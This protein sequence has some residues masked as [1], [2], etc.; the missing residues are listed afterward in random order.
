MGKPRKVFVSVLGT[1][2]YEKCQ[3]EDSKPTRFIQQA[4]LEWLKADD[5]TENDRVLIFTTN[6]AK[7]KNWSVKDKRS[8]NKDA[9]AEEYIGLQYV[10]DDMRLA[11]KVEAVDIPDGK[12]EAEMWDVFGRIYDKLEDRDQ[13]YFDLTHAFRYLP[14]LV[15][16]LGQYAG[17]LKKTEIKSVTYGNYEA[18]DKGTNVAPINNLMPLVTLL[19]Y[20]QAAADFEEYG[21][22]KAIGDAVAATDA[23]ILSK[24]KQGQFKKE[25]EILSK[26]LLKLNKDLSTCRG[27]ELMSGKTVND[28]QKN[29]ANIKEFGVLP[30]PI[31]NILEN[32]GKKLQVFNMGR[33]ED[34]LLNSIDWCLKNGM[35]QQGYTLCQESITTLLYDRLDNC[36]VGKDAELSMRNFIN[37]LLG[38]SDADISNEE[39]W[40]GNIV[41]HKCYFRSLLKIP[42]IQVLRRKYIELQVNRNAINHGG[43][44]NRR[45]SN[46]LIM[47]FPQII[48]DCIDA[49][50]TI[51]DKYGEKIIE[52]PALLIN[53]SN[54]PYASWTEE[55]RKAAEAYGRCEDMVFPQVDP[56]M[57]DSELEK[58]VADYERRILERAKTADVTMHVMGEMTF[59]F[60]LIQRLRSRGIVCIASC[61]RREVVELDGHTRQSTFRFGG[62]RRYF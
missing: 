10:L 35:V 33:L 49:T 7:E 40:K 47:K 16:V 46:V 57:N 2:F 29:I 13:L 62:F 30:L 31:Y 20:T 55:Q 44:T 38:M 23:S 52:N 39:R 5:W 1:G 50:R 60:A 56:A 45:E 6:S 48:T 59:C 3:Y 8:K 11:A 21:N 54:H 15:L 42:E 24:K 26:G 53:L 19:D 58:L 18:R 14:M 4:T 22:M 37:S 61:T 36:F 34:N 28:V 43:F 9:Y 12:N 51:L 32:V 25:A 27:K 17:H 41:F